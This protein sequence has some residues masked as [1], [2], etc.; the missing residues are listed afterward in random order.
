MTDL[1]P[2]SHQVPP[3][4]VLLRAA[5]PFPF[6]PRL[7]VRGRH[8]HGAVLCYGVRF[9]MGHQCLLSR[10]FFSRVVAMC[11]YHRLS[12]ASLSLALACCLSVPFF[13]LPGATNGAMQAN[14]YA[15]TCFGACMCSRL[16]PFLFHLPATAPFGRCCKSASAATLPS[17]FHAH[18]ILIL[19]LLP[20]SVIIP[21]L[22]LGLRECA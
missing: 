22:P 11:V 7:G 13:A 21:A 5:C 8:A 18:I 17:A 15:W 10:S 2:A 1:L 20:F 4:L 16:T 19:S 9:P 6:A 3:P 12:H 14:P